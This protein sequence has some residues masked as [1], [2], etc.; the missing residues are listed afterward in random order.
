MA[1]KP[2]KTE[3]IA[4]LT[5]SEVFADLPISILDIIDR[6]RRLDMLDYYAADSIAQVP[7][8]MEGLSHLDTVT[9]SYLKVIITP[10][11]DLAIKVLP[12]KKSPI[13]LTAYTIGDKNQAYDTD[14]RF[15]DTEFNEIKRDKLIKIATLS[16]F[17]SYPDKETRKLVESLVPFPTIRYEAEPDGTGLSAELTVGQ[18][19]SADDY[20]RIKKYLRGKLHYRWT[21]S[22]FN[23]EK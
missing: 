3:D 13:I 6:S 19:M 11:T 4:P 16:E 23:L 10:V 18:F 17:F 7:N 1:T 9:P 5:S 22:K 21:G 8:A 20:A 14:L 12:G 15:Y 2:D